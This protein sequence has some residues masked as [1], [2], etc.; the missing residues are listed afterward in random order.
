MKTLFRYACAFVLAFSMAIPA[1]AS[2]PSMPLWQKRAGPILPVNSSNEASLVKYDG[3]LVM[4]VFNRTPL[5]SQVLFYDLSDGENAIL[6]ASRPWGAAMGGTVVDD[7]GVLHLYGVNPPATNNPP[8]NSIVHVTVDANWNLSAPNVIIGPSGMGFN[9]IEVAKT[10]LGYVLAVEQAYSNG[11][12]AE[13]YILSQNPAFQSFT[14]LYSFGNASDFTGKSRIRSMP[15][16][17]TYVTSDSI[18]GQTRIARTQNFTTW[19]FSTSPFSFLGPD[20]GDAYP[21][22]VGGPIFYNGNVTWEEWNGE[23]IAIYFQG[24]EVDNA[25][26][27]IAKFDGTLAD[28]FAKFTFQP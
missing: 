1:F 6:I 7:Q 22:V 15:D 24:N 10:P 9:N 11:I 21:G 18:T 13:S 27:R 4:V 28:L 26:L 2:A 19:K 16:G 23:V 5:A 8:Y 12:K 25:S 17:W 14:V 20:H 3:K